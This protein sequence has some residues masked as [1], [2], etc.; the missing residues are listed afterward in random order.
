MMLRAALGVIFVGC[1]CAAVVAWCFAAYHQTAFV[2]LW[3]PFKRRAVR[4]EIEARV[5]VFFPIISHDLPEDC[6]RHG[7]RACWAMLAFVALCA[8]G[9]GALFL[10]GPSGGDATPPLIAPGPL[11]GISG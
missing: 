9:A 7:Q 5:N 3:L 10:R 11:N 8:V 6:R 1:L 4:G 2:R